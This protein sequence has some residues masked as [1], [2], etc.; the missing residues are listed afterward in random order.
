MSALTCISA[1]QI[2]LVRQKSFPV[3]QKTFPVPLR[4]NQAFE[5][6]TVVAVALLV[7]L[8]AEGRSRSAGASVR[9]FFCRIRSA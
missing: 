6:Y 8:D 1:G 9:A 3:P 5:R 7:L 2:S 4:R